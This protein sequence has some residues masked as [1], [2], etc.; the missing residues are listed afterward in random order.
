MSLVFSFRSR[1]HQVSTE[2]YQRLSKIIKVIPFPHGAG[3]WQDQ[4][5]IRDSCSSRQ[6]LSPPL[7]ED[8]EGAGW[9]L[10]P[11]PWHGDLVPGY[12]K[13]RVAL[14]RS[15]WTES[16]NAENF[17][18][19]H[20]LLWHDL[21]AAFGSCWLISGWELLQAQPGGLKTCCSHCHA[22]LLDLASKIKDSWE[23]GPTRS[24]DADARAILQRPL[25]W[26]L[27]ANASPVVCH[28][29][30]MMS[31][32]PSTS[33]EVYDCN[34]SQHRKLIGISRDCRGFS[35]SLVSS[36]TS[37]RRILSKSSARS[38]AAS[39]CAC[40]REGLPL[41]AWHCEW[42]NQHNTGNDWKWHY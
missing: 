27:L 20:G 29:F 30:C 21:H 7:P 4:L 8:V 16:S 10:A 9:W 6:R 25:G 41:S 2:F 24:Q 19:T 39:T 5:W 33:N 26:K 17:H 37:R 28:D 40:K 35:A 23:S 11:E 42:G 12:P 18:G 13:M 34:V 1:F 3:T 38:T 31:N 22:N 36:V 15:T 32:H 14:L